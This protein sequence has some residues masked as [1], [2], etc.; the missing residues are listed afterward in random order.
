MVSCV[1]PRQNCV[2]FFASNARVG[3]HTLVLG[4][5]ALLFAS[6]RDRCVVQRVGHQQNCVAFCFELR[7]VSPR[8]G[9]RR[10][11]TIFARYLPGVVV[12]DTSVGRSTFYLF[13]YLHKCRPR[14][15]SARA[16]VLLLIVGRTA[17]RCCTILIPCIGS[18]QEKCPA[19]CD[20]CP[21]LHGCVAFGRVCWVSWVFLVGVPNLPK[22]RV[23][24]Y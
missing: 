18:R 10:N 6:N 1:G 9:S 23:P 11:C 24:V 7:R 22:C 12:A 3:F 19:L 5:S 15:C 13:I 2:V 8:I 14:R 16:L 21:C 4:R 17:V 20:M